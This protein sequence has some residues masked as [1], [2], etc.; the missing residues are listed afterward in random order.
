MHTGEVGGLK[1]IRFSWA[2]IVTQKEYFSR[3]PKANAKKKSIELQPVK[4]MFK[5]GCS[6]FGFL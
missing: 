6:H 2:K 4:V 3:Y 5:E 1:L